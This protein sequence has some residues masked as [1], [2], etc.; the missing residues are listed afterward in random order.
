MTL[1]LPILHL[2]CRAN[3][4]RGVNG[5]I[6]SRILIQVMCVFVYAFLPTYCKEGP[7]KL[8]SECVRVKEEP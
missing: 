7:Y 6:L 2:G 4:H 1:N 5:C 3:G 8:V